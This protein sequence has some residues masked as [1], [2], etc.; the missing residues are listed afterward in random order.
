[1]MWASSI[2]S[3]KD[4]AQPVLRALKSRL[5]AEQAC[6]GRFPRMHGTGHSIF[7]SDEHSLKGQNQ[8]Y[9][10]IF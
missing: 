5:R 8:D 7:G 4:C 9:L 3:S 6:S 1:M 2:G 10:Q